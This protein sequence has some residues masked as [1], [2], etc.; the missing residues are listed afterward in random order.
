MKARFYLFVLACVLLALPT[1]THAEECPGKGGKAY[2]S[3][4]DQTVYLVTE[5][6][7]KKAFTNADIYFTH[8]DS[9]DE[10]TQIDNDTL[11]SIEFAEDGTIPLGPKA[12]LK[13]G[14][15][16]KL[17]DDPKVYVMIQGNLHWVETEE[18][19][20]AYGLEF[21][22]VEVISEELFETFT[23]GPDLVD[24]FNYPDYLAVKY[25]NDPKVY[26]IVT[27]E[28]GFKIKRHVA[29]EEIFDE[30]NY[31]FDRVVNIPDDFSFFEGDPINK[32]E[33]LPELVDPENPPIEVV[34]SLPSEEDIAALFLDAGLDLPL[35][36]SDLKPL[37]PRARE[38]YWEGE[39]IFEDPYLG[40]SMRN[41]QKWDATWLDNTNGENGIDVEYTFSPGLELGCDLD[42]FQDECEGV[43]TISFTVLSTGEEAEASAQFY[44]AF[45]NSFF[46]EMT[47]T[48]EVNYLGSLDA[49]IVT[50][51]ITDPISQERAVTR[52]A[53]AQD[54]H[55]GFN[56]IEVYL[57][58][59]QDTYGD[60]I[61]S[62]RKS[63]NYIGLSSREFYD[64]V[65]LEEDQ[66]YSER[67]TSM[68]NDRTYDLE[69]TLDTKRSIIQTD[70]AEDSLYS[71]SGL[72]YREYEITL[73]DIVSLSSYIA[74][75]IYI[76]ITPTSRDTVDEARYTPPAYEDLIT[77]I[78]VEDSMWGQ[79]EMVDAFGGKDAV[80]SHIVYLIDGDVYHAVL[81]EVVVGNMHYEFSLFSQNNDIKKALKIFEEML[82]TA[83]ID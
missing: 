72:F 13:N 48:D 80:R 39:F 41:P 28:F 63:F 24:P 15:V 78:G 46:D 8:F 35:I 9:W 68:I 65:S 4:G 19:Y 50:G 20:K 83:V 69:V 77:G 12:E 82:A 22:K 31:R 53:F 32:I 26:L 55:I 66:V 27:N 3:A 17:L 21:S 59:D 79:L 70:I 43:P 51:I 54:G 64:S 1:A 62:M 42:P 34:V 18:V 52:A 5:E 23:I 58:D 81:V 10:I 44:A 11:L 71:E 45:L 36:D 56:F 6:C 25:E 30:L 57:E 61:E 16:V 74:P 14:S 67:T 29:N 37:E 47:V 49:T 38:G 2:S 60:T 40:V 7:T 75:T 73:T 33:D 76:D